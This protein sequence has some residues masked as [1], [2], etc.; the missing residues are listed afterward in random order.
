S[1]VGSPAR[2]IAT[3]STVVG[4][5]SLAILWLVAFRGRGRLGDPALVCALAVAVVL[6][7]SKVLSPQ[8][9]V[10]LVP[11]VALVRGRAGLAACARLGAACVLTRLVYPDRYE[12]LVADDRLP[13]ALLALRNGLLV[14]VAA[15]LATAFVRR[16]QGEGVAK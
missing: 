9:L 3:A 8:F 2:E 12:E 11:L 13:V 15:L 7:F 5:V 6:L 14:A 10:W 16:L 4:A 1:L